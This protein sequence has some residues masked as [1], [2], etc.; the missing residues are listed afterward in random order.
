MHAASKNS[1]LR[2][3]SPKLL[4]CFT[5][6]TK[7]LENKISRKG[8]C[9]IQSTSWLAWLRP[10]NGFWKQSGKCQTSCCS[11]GKVSQLMQNQTEWLRTNSKKERKSWSRSCLVTVS[12]DLEQCT[13]LLALNWHPL[14]TLCSCQTTMT[15]AVHTL[16]ARTDLLFSSIARC[17]CRSTTKICMRESKLERLKLKTS[18]QRYWLLNSLAAFLISHP[19]LL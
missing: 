11:S 6:W 19:K 1:I 9:H 14:G 12:Q 15:A 7:A 13:K 16:N 18:L 17:P 4:A 8:G 3:Q 5:Q 10:K 2:T